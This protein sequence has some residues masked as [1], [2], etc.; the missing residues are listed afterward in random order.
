MK[1]QWGIRVHEELGLKRR[2][3]LPEEPRGQHTDRGNGKPPTMGLAE[4]PH[5]I[6]HVP[7]PPNRVQF[8]CVQCAFNAAVLNKNSRLGEL[9]VQ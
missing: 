9:K 8:A 7:S 5:H 1:R 4:S 2:D 3:S 6:R